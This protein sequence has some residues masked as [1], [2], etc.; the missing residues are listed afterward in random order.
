[1]S[2]I[3]RRIRPRWRQ[4]VGTDPVLLLSRPDCGLCVR[5]LPHVL[6]AFG[7]DDVVVVDITRHR[8]LEDRYVFRIPVLLF[9]GRVLA[10]G[11]ISAD[12][13]RVARVKRDAMRSERRQR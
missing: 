3:W 10:E 4:S 6:R 12:G 1:M 13:A 7:H 5:A 9:E 11:D 8:E 2:A